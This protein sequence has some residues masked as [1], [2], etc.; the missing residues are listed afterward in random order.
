MVHNE[1]YQPIVHFHT[2]LCLNILFESVTKSKRLRIY[3]KN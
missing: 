3:F 1:T 2:I